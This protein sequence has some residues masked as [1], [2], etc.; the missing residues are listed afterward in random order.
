MAGKN[1]FAILRM[2]R[3]FESRLLISILSRT[4]LRPIATR[5]GNTHMTRLTFPEYRALALSPHPIM[6]NN[7]QLPGSP[8]RVDLVAGRNTAAM[9]TLGVGAPPG[10]PISRSKD[11]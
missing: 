9:A 8:A 10:S 6:A 2:E 3:L 11:S 4:H 5:I 7:L 1:R